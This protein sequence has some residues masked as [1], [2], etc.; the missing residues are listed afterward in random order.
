MSAKKSGDRWYRVYLGV[1]FILLLLAVVLFIYGSVT[2]RMP[3]P[4]LPGKGVF[5]LRT[6][7]LHG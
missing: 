2:N 1:L 7:L 6:M 4:K 5:A 3:Q